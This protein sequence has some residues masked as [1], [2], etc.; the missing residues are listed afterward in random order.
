MF[1]VRVEKTTKQ[2]TGALRV[3]C[4]SVTGDCITM[5]KD[6]VLCK[7]SLQQDGS[8]S[9]QW[10]RQLS[11]HSPVSRIC[12]TDTGDIIMADRW[13]ENSTVFWFD[14]DMKRI[15]SWQQDGELIAC[16][17][18]P[19]TVYFVMEGVECYVEIRNQKGEVLQLK[20]KEVTWRDCPSVCE[21]G[22]TGKLAVV[23]NS[24]KSVYGDSH[25]NLHILSGIGKAQ[26]SLHHQIILLV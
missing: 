7:F 17:P 16:L 10:R 22:R 23:S 1:T 12:L 14:Q 26:R 21:D 2:N 9:E 15:D 3:K 11:E 20:P 25:C 13:S 4:I 6:G 18:G 19:R 5:P 24:R 8:Y